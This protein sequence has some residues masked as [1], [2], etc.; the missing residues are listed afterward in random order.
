MLDVHER[1]DELKESGLYQRMRLVSG[2]QG[3]RVV[4]DGR[5]VLLLCSNGYLGLADHPQVREAAADAAMRWG[6]GAAGSRLVSGTMT[7]HRRLEE[8]L[9]EHV[10]AES[11]L[12]F[13]SAYLAN[14]G[15]IPALT[16]PGEVVF[17]DAECHPS[18]ADGC[19]L[20]AAEHV[21]YRHNDV[22]HLAWLLRQADGRGALIA[23]DAVF[24]A[25]GDRAPLEE[26]VELAGRRRVR[27]LVDESHGI[28]CLGPEGRGAVADAG[29]D[30]EVDLIVGSLGTAL[31]AAGGFVAC[32]H[33]VA[34][35]LA[36]TARTFGACTAPPPV[37]L[38]AALAALQLIVDQPRRVER[39]AENA[40]VLREALARE[41]FDVSASTT[42][43]IPLAIGDPATARRIADAALEQGV[44]VETAWSG[45][46]VALVRTTVM[47]SHT[48]TELREA[49]QV[50]AR[51]A[52]RTGFRPG[53]APPAIASHA[54]ETLPRAA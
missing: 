24:A 30:G 19:R 2:P 38:A 16:R 49:A 23:T 41:S 15:V 42:Q 9:A 39:L 46:D 22:D 8:A 31:G 53:Q 35:C 32:D 54:A 17:S 33:A 4:L 44:F 12:L 25:D 48:R 1:L 6:V 34:G 21:T 52:L 51:A 27:L 11:V 18:I 5:P 13:G 47:A 40:D 10:G 14:V 45:Q 26:L 37:V 36:R 43:I 20:A 29:L 28:G 50:L 3:P 7:L